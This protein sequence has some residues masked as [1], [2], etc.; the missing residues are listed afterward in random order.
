FMDPS[1]SSA[2][3]SVSQNSV[4][5]DVVDVS[6]VPSGSSLNALTE[7]IVAYEKESNETHAFKNNLACVNVFIFKL[8][9][10][11]T[12][13]SFV[14][15]SNFDTPGGTVYYIPKVSADVLLVKGNVYDSVDD[16]VV[17]YMKYSAEAGFVVRRSCQK[18][19]RNGDVKQK[20]LV[21]NRKGCP[22]GIH[23]DTL[24]LENSDKQ[25]RNSNLHITGCKARVV[26]NLV[27]YT[28]KF[29]LN[30]FDTIH[31][32]ELKL[33]KFK[34]LS[35]RERQLT[36]LEQ[37]FIMKAASVNIGATRAHHLLTGD[38]DAQM[39]IHKIENR[40]KHVSEFLFDYFVENAELSVI[41]WA[42]EVSKYN[43]MEF[44][45][46]IQDGVCSPYSD[47]QSQEV[48][49]SSIVFTNQDGA[50]RNAI[51]AEFAGSKHRLC[52]W[53]I[54]QKLHAKNA[55]VE[56]IPQQYI[57]RHWTKNLIPAALRNKRNIY[58]EKNVVVE[59]FANEE[60]SIVDHCVHLLS[61]DEPSKD[62]PRLGAF[63]EKLKS[64]KK[65]VEADCPNPPSKN[66]TDN[67]EQ[68]VGVP[69]PPAVDETVL[70]T[71]AKPIPKNAQEQNPGEQRDESNM[72]IKLSKELLTELQNNT[73]SGRSE[74]DVIEHIGKILEILD[75]VKIAGVDPFQLRM[76]AFPLSLSKGAKECDEIGEWKYFH[77]RRMCDDDEEGRD[78]LEFIPWRNSKF[79]D[80]KKVDETTK[81]ALLYTW[82]EIGKEEGLL[83]DE[84]SSNE[85]WKEQEYGNPPKDSFPKPCFE[86]D[87]N[88][89]NENNQEHLQIEWIGDN[90]EFLAICTRE[91]NSWERTVNGVSKATPPDPI[92]VATNVISLFLTSP[93]TPQPSSVFISQIQS[94][95]NVNPKLV[96][97]H[98]MVTRFRVGTNRPAHRLNLHVS[99][100]SPLQKSYSEA[101]ND[102]NWK[103]AMT[104]E[105]NALVK[106]KTWTIVHRPTDAYIVRCMWSFR[107]KYLANDTLSCYKARLVANDSSRSMLDVKNAFL[108]RDLFETVYMHQPLEYRDSIHPDY[109]CL[110]Q[111]SL[112]GIKQGPRTWFRQFAAYTTHVGFSHSCCDSSLFIYRKGTHTT[113][114]LLYVDD[115][116]STALSEILLQRIIASLHKEFSMMDLVSLSYFLVI[117]VTCDS[118]GM[119]LSLRKYDIEILEWPH[120]VSCNP[121][122]TLVDTESKL[123]VAERL[124]WF[125]CLFMSAFC[126]SWHIMQAYFCV[127]KNANVEMIQ[128]KYVLRRWTKN[129]INAAL[130]NKRNI[131]GEKNVVVENFANEAT[132][133]VDHCVHLLSKD[134]PR[135]GAFVEKLKSL[136]KEV[137][138]D[139]PNPP[140]KNKTDNLEQL[141]GVSK[142]PAVDVNNPTVG[143]T[144]G[145][146]KL[147]IKG[148]KEKAIK[149]S[150]KIKMKLWF[151]KKCVKRKLWLKKACQEE[152]VVQKEV[153]QEEVVQE[154]IDLAKDEEELVKEDEELIHE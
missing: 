117:F 154:K 104:G 51:E 9:A 137:E 22:K 121:S 147:R 10:L 14:T 86:M 50:M 58:G 120:M 28:R 76:K 6:C 73:F 81:R 70:R 115:I 93:D 106:N 31:N 129:L 89:H 20:Y 67:L 80:H 84:V 131:Y 92:H 4:S 21:C 87:K 62:E 126:E 114:L 46:V 63:V 143:S 83:N 140:S 60:T 23:V 127:F 74:E 139:C 136:K 52:I 150:L 66:K 109:V 116:V 45:D 18:R 102:P 25:K 82:I 12:P 29:V 19:L 105:Y 57:L 98:P 144:K 69:K 130:K 72:K 110:L 134:K 32:H 1:H 118:S 78:P 122:R 123:G 108:H 38:S 85:E 68:L 128:Q 71:M 11:C 59:N 146:K 77:L 141:V 94:T 48:K 7:E 100:I 61:K 88:N 75:L 54:T 41:F 3:S 65:E 30:V 27:L 103:N 40:K 64:L 35:K 95:L 42:D 152:V 142:P 24:D 55:N 47:R 97:V 151:E 112:Y 91:C 49:A 101:F 56:M 44:G 36:Y 17:A 107:H 16:C 96:S 125:S 149:K 90:E 2:L 145:Q 111:R 132:S 153:C 13:E 148:G 26:F 135:L 8:D 33:E 39:L 138:V 34:H 43:Y 113:Y 79:K 119:F 37:A 124:R 15:H 5:F 133:I 99:F 53:H